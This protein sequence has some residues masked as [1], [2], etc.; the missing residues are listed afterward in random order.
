M[1]KNKEAALARVREEIEKIDKNENK[2]M[3]FVIDTKGIPS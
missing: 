2:V 3:F 1:S